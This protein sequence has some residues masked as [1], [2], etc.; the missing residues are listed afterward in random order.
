MNTITE[1]LFTEL[2]DQI[3]FN[4]RNSETISYGDFITYYSYFNF[5]CVA[6]KYNPNFIASAK[7]VAQYLSRV[8]V[9]AQDLSEKMMIEKAKT[10]IASLKNIKKDNN[11][12]LEIARNRVRH[13]E[14]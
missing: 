6:S 5:L 9:S 8:K 11:Q 14:K 13:S 2:V 3:N 1:K 12:E 7:N 4:I 10:D